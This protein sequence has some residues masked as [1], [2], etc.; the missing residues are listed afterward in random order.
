MTQWRGP[1]QPRT[2]LE[3]RIRERRQTFEEF[4]EF[5][6]EFARDQKEQGTLSVRHLQ[7]LVAG[8]RPDGGPLGP[9]RPATARLLERIFGVSIDELLSEPTDVPCNEDSASELRQMLNAARRVDPVAIEL[10]EE[11]LNAVRRLDRQLGA[12]VAYD[13][14]R[15]KARQVDRLRTYSTLPGVRAKLAALLSE[16]HTLAGWQALDTGS[17]SDSWQHYDNAKAAAAESDDASFVVHAMAEQSFV[18]LDINKSGEAVDLITDARAQAKRS[19]PSLLRAWLAAAHGEALAA[20]GRRNGSLRAFDESA[21]LLGAGSEDSGGPYVV[22]D[23]VHL[24][25]WRG[26]ALARFG[27]MEAVNVLSN[28]LDRL[29]PSFTRAETALRVDLAT[30][31][32]SQGEP[33]AARA[34]ASVARRLAAEIGSA[35]QDRR[36]R[37]LAGQL[38]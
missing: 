28:A 36:L 17:I 14:V 12:I 29:D 5:A 20:N 7:R 21:E 32:V 30:A 15:V 6:D 2:V 34:H 16:L 13:E 18:L 1:G 9:V 8:R 4:V 33:E 10:F 19:S 35:R 11:Q 27:D 38:R 31:F 3:Q 37:M 23:A 25:R 26:H 22:L 24:A